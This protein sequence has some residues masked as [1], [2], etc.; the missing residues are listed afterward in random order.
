MVGMNNYNK[1]SNA[2]NNPH[3]NYILIIFCLL[4]YSFHLHKLFATKQE[5]ESRHM[6]YLTY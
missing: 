3:R 2:T 6:T 1:K 4:N 5:D